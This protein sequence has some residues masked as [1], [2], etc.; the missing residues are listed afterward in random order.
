MLLFDDSGTSL[1]VVSS[2][3]VK[4][5]SSSITALESNAATPSPIVSPSPERV[6]LSSN[7]A[8]SSSCRSLPESL[9]DSSFGSVASL[10]AVRASFCW[11]SIT[12]HSISVSLPCWT[13]SEIPND[14]SR[15]CLWAFGVPSSSVR[16]DAVLRLIPSE[17]LFSWERHSTS[18]TEEACV[19]GPS[20]AS[21]AEIGEASTVAPA[22]SL[23]SVL[24]SL[25]MPDPTSFF[26]VGES[27]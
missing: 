4:R 21:G 14:N 1:E 8:V 23:R 20:D 11:C 24:S 9:V 6:A 15:L 10:M 3:L 25:K 26:A 2:R 13:W 18:E 22:S 12:G 17:S 7:S 19:D 16:G 27:A 5:C